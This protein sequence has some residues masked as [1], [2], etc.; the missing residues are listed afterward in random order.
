MTT[1]P[2]DF[3]KIFAGL[4]ARG[5]REETTQLGG[6]SLRAV[7]RP[8]GREGGWDRHPHTA[9][10]VIVWSGNFTAEFRDHTFAPSA[11]QCCVVPRGAGHR[12]TSRN[13]AEVILF[14]Q[15]V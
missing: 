10:T 13:G 3:P 6:V 5:E 1:G 11:G 14:Q 12:G 9:E 7:R 4:A 2:S 15:E 8:G